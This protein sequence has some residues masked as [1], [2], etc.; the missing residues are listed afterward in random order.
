MPFD[1]YQYVFISIFFSYI[2]F[3]DFKLYFLNIVWVHGSNYLQGN[4]LMKV[5]VYGRFGLFVTLKFV[6][7]YS[8]FF[9]KKFND[10]MINFP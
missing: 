3:G 1:F 2:D 9:L 5:F 10:S 7:R 4:F 8:P 6:L